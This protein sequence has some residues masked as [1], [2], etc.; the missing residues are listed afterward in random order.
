MTSLHLIGYA[1]GLAGVDV[2][3]GEGPVTIQAALN[4]N[5]EWNA[6]LKP[7][8]DKAISLLQTV[9]QLCEAL[10][11]QVSQALRQKQR[12]VVLGGDHSSA[13]GTW[14]GVYDVLH[15]E[16]EIGLIWV[17]AHMDSHTPETTHSGRL[18]G[19]PLASLLGYGHDALTNILHATPKL[20]P[21]NVC[22]LGVRSFEAG[23]AAFLEQL[24]V[25]VYFMEEIKQRGF[26]T[27]WEEA[28]AH[29]N[30]HTVGYGIS[31]D[32]DGIDPGDAPGVGVP[33]PDGILAT[34]IYQVFSSTA[35]DPRLLLTEIVEF[36]PSRDYDHLTEKLIVS[37]IEQI[38]KGVA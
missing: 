37:F 28:K 11:I 15:S 23:E 13:I 17:D 30:R 5:Y 9:S 12:V 34:D 8:Q 20:K 10:A 29:V 18:H 7:S 22:L 36:D 19:M 2:R 21:E 31:L 3:C 6:I 1:S 24:N 26:V 38:A 33:E 4:N 32:L 14:S 35:S 27:V 25:K 16:G